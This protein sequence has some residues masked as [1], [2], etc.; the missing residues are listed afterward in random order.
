M[1]CFMLNA[2]AICFDVFGALVEQARFA[3]NINYIS[4]QNNL[5]INL[6]KLLQSPLCEGK[7]VFSKVIT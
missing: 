3:F 5:N 1:L 7:F 2:Y 6:A 4:W